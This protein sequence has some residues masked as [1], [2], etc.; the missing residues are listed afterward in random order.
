MLLPEKPSFRGFGQWGMTF[1]R[2]R[3]R[4]LQDA[5]TPPHRRL[6][7]GC[8]E[9]PPAWGD[10][11]RRAVR[12]MSLVA[13][14]TGAAYGIGAE[15]AV[16]L[17]RDGFDLGLVAESEPATTADR[18]RDIG[19]RAQAIAADFR[20]PAAAAEVVTEAVRK[21]DGLDV[22][23][24]N[25]GVTMQKPFLETTPAELNDLLA[26]NFVSA[27]LACRAAIPHMRER[28]GGSVVNVSS[29]HSLFG[30][31]GHTAYASSKGALN[32][33]TRA[34]AVEFAPDRI[35]VNA[36]APGLVEVERYFRTPGYTTEKGDGLVPWPRIGKPADVAEFV[37][38]LCSPAAEYVTGQ[39]ISVDGGS[40]A[41]MSFDWR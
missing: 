34:L 40:S 7:W 11:E 5:A 23:V 24:N 10:R 32:A 16:R 1:T 19:K 27:W 22:L 29:I 17:A 8:L 15:I 30:L 28:G 12:F 36:I 25:A 31:S 18:V 38:F 33:L 41:L 21:L 13:V 39:V 35:R 20:D 26:I 6:S 3:R 9:Q 37:G 4:P 14:V 2:L